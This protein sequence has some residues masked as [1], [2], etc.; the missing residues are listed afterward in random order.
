LALAKSLRRARKRAEGRAR[1][2]N[3]RRPR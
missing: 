2:T 3:G 1:P